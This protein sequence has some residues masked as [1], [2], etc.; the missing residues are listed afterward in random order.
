[1]PVFLVAALDISNNE[2]FSLMDRASSL[3]SGEVYYT[4]LIGQN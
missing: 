1:M 3:I 4:R 2:D